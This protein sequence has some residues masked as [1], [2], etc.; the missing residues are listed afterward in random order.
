MSFIVSIFLTAFLCSIPFG[1][2]I[3]TLFFDIDPRQHHSKN[4]GMS[5]TWRCCGAVA[6]LVTLL[7]D[8]GKAVLSLWI[9]T[10]LGSPY[11]FTVGFLCVLFHCFSIYLNGKGGKGVACAAG[12][13]VFFAPQIWCTA[14]AT[15]VITR[16]LS[17]KASVA[18]LCATFTTLIH[19]F[20][21]ES[22]FAPCISLIGLL[23]LIRHK[24][25]IDR[26]RKKQELNL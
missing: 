21:F 5:N 2:I 26:L 8:T 24:E 1:L 6:G 7:L 4:I 10:R 15:W 19:T 20:L 16:F 22:W 25:N 11:L 18:S 17:N 14:I 3:A 23:I 13:I 9:A 12:V